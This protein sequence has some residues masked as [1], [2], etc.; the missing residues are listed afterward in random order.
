MS[1][2]IVKCLTTIELDLGSEDIVRIVYAALEPESHTAPSE[3]AVTSF[4][5]RGSTLVI[6]IEAGD[7]TAMRA[8]T[9]SFLSWISA[10]VN[11]INMIL[12]QNP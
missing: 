11:T 8:A 6:T 9:N 1:N 7:L 2:E 10:C 4:S 3:R 5:Q 12:G